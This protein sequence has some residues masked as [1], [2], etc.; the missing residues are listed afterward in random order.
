[1]DAKRLDRWYK[2]HL[3]GFREAEQS[4]EIGKDDLM[5]RRDGEEQRIRVP[6]KKPENMGAYMA[7]D[8]KTIDGVCY[9]I[10]SNR[11]TSK[12]AL[13]AATLKTS[14]LHR[15]LDSIPFKAKMGVRSITR[16]MAPNYDWPARTAFMNAYHVADK[17]HVLREILEQL[18]SVRIRH[19]QELLTLERKRSKTDEEKQLLKEKLSNEETRKQLLH[20]SRGLLFK[21]RDEW[22]K[23]QAERAGILFRL[24]PEIKQAYAYC[25]KIR[26]W[27]RPIGP[28]YSDRKQKKKETDLQL[29]VRNGVESKV[30]E[31]KN[32][33]H[34]LSANATPIL[35]Y[36]Y[37]RESNAKAEAL[38]QNL[39]RFINVNYG[40]RN[41][42]FFLYRI[43]IHFS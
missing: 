39:R 3:S 26:K 33:A 28:H 23:D 7:I 35:H 20:R 5:V 18:Q 11:E 38:N 37:R 2:D 27:Y 29:L 19:R 14:E 4:G 40:S 8:E 43:S 16:D 12:I 36:F 25:E 32:I 13:M 9:T 17:F 30:E 10:L 21:H 34:F 41:S 6:I 15:C 24:Y 31:V 1:M 42:D 22:T